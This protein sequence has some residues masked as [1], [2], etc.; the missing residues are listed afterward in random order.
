MPQPIS[1]FF[2]KLGLPFRNVR[3]SWGAQNG[4]VV[5]LRTWAHE[6]DFKTRRVVVL[7]KTAGYAGYGDSGSLGL[8]ERIVQLESMWKG[9]IAA[10]TVMAN[11]HDPG[12]FALTIKDYRDDVVFAIKELIHQEDGAILAVLGAELIAV[13]NF[14]AHSKSHLTATGVGAFPADDSLRTGLTTA[15]YLEKVAAIRAWLVAT[16]EKRELVT[17]GDLMNKF[18][19]SFF[20][21]RNA[22]ARLGHECRDAG[23]PI[24]TAVI[25]DKETL[26]CSDGLR[27]EFGIEDDEAERTRCYAHWAPQA[28]SP[29][30]C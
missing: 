11:A 15:G 24:I 5:L 9:G 6:F 10:Y 7:D 28:H 23:L 20:M 17:Y 14:A 27:A 12:V 22:M 25:V 30:R 18:A 19:M 4:N 29:C 13:K 1:H 2:E 21:M 3:W 26:R 16:C 8:D